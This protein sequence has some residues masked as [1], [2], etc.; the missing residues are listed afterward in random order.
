MCAASTVILSFRINCSV[1]ITNVPSLAIFESRSPGS[2]EQEHVLAIKMFDSQEPIKITKRSRWLQYYCINRDPN[3]GRH[4][5]RAGERV[6]LL[7]VTSSDA[8]VKV[9]EFRNARSISAAAYRRRDICQCCYYTCLLIYRE[10]DQILSEEL[11]IYVTITRTR[12]G[13]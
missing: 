9:N 6:I 8:L 12:I 13:I 11:C 5:T 1:G 7:N 4:G 3:R 10:E 2:A